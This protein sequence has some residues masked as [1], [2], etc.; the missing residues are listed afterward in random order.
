MVIM[1]YITL[2]GGGQRMYL[3]RKIDGFLAE[4]KSDPE[5]CYRN[6]FR[7]RREV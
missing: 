3:E 7:Q 1:N 4:W 2:I 5:K 6:Q